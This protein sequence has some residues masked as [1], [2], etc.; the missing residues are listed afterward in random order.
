MAAPRRS[1]QR[2]GI[3]RGRRSRTEV[4]SQAWISAHGQQAGTPLRDSPTLPP[5]GRARRRIAGER[6]DSFLRLKPRRRRRV[7]T[8]FRRRTGEGRLMS[9]AAKI[10]ALI[11]DDEPDARLQIRNLLAAHADVEVV[12]EC[13][14]GYEA[15]DAVERHAP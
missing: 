3:A 14:N 15:L 1:R 9:E 5:L 6:R 11:V 10:R 4:G 13:C 12:R 2:A 8:A 7:F